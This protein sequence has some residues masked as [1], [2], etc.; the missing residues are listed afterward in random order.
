[1]ARAVERMAA[2]FERPT[3]L[4]DFPELELLADQS[5]S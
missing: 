3:G 5:G 1:M 4:V 2:V